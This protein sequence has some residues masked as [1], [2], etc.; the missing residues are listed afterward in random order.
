MSTYLHKSTVPTEKMT[1][2]DKTDNGFTI[3]VVRLPTTLSPMDTGFAIL[4][5]I[6]LFADNVIY[7]R[8]DGCKMEVYFLPDV[9]GM[10][11]Q[12]KERGLLKRIDI[13]KILMSNEVIVWDECGGKYLIAHKSI[14]NYQN[15][16]RLHK[17]IQNSNR[18]YVSYMEL[19]E[20]HE[21][22]Y[23]E[24]PIISVQKKVLQTAELYPLDSSQYA[25]IKFESINPETLNDQK[26]AIVTSG[27][28]SKNRNDTLRQVCTTPDNSSHSG[29]CFIDFET[30]NVASLHSAETSS[31]E[32][33]P[34]DQYVHTSSLPAVRKPPRYQKYST[35]SSR[36]QTYSGW[37]HTTPTV[38]ECV[39]AGFFYTGDNDLIRCY[40]CGI[41]LK[42]F[43]PMDNPM[44][45]HIKHVPTCPYLESIFGK[46]GLKLQ[47]AQIHKI[48][49]EN[50]RRRQYEE[51]LSHGGTNDGNQI[52]R[53]PQ[54]NTFEFR[55]RTFENVNFRCIKTPDQLAEAGLYYTGVGDEVRCF[56]CNGGLRNWEEN[57]DPWTEHCKWFPSCGFAREMKGAAFIERIQQNMNATSEMLNTTSYTPESR[58]S[59][60][61]QLD[62]N[63]DTLRTTCLEDMGFNIEAF[64]NAVHRLRQNGITFPNIED[65]VNEI[66]QFEK[67][68]T[69][70]APTDVYKENKR[71]KGMLI[72]Q[73]CKI[74]NSNALFLPCAHHVMC[75]NCAHD[76]RKCPL[77]QRHVNDIVRT[78]M[79]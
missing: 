65:I 75:F 77:C 64:D 10:I 78:Y 63:L 13:F 7:Y 67:V 68:G 50:V 33:V 16:E 58:K 61:S 57:D 72:C 44:V 23:K 54:F 56:S 19:E 52:I 43:S 66:A 74:N 32:A 24:R 41:G 38:E 42:D 17:Y 35:E 22:N 39:F 51:F 3:T 79:G 2:Y 1:E 4:R 28:S 5:L 6:A 40:Q 20:L 26:A 76:V 71:L 8:R 29:A 73:I 53:S 45:E 55:I 46:D 70:A 49:P 36:F 48:D 47:Q 12:M 11:R 21:T 59:D 37:P 62:F 9:P 31:N 69:E 15:F 14:D 25:L 30:N 18:R 27:S 34:A 60:N